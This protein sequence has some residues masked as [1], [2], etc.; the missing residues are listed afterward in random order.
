[1]FFSFSDSFDMYIGQAPS[2]VSPRK[3]KGF[4]NKY[5]AEQLQDIDRKL[6]F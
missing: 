2:D 1:M 3:Q 6:Q 5:I 4:M